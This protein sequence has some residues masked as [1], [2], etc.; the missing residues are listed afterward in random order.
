MGLPATSTKALETPR[1]ARLAPRSPATRIASKRIAQWWLGQAKSDSGRA[2]GRVHGAATKRQDFVQTGA[3]YGGRDAE[4]VGDSEGEEGQDR[5]S[6]GGLPEA[7]RHGARER[8]GHPGLRLPSAEG[9]PERLRGL[10]EVRGRRRLQEARR[11]PAREQRRLRRRA[12]GPSGA[13]APR[14]GLEPY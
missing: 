4:P 9:R 11:E 12:R 5:R 6:Q 2:V 8:A 14:R 13:D 1:T 3:K 10:R 7:R